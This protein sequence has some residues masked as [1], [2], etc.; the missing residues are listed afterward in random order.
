MV[1]IAWPVSDPELLAM[2]SLLSANDVPAVKLP[3]PSPGCCPYR[4]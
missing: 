2:T 4:L 1:P 3:S